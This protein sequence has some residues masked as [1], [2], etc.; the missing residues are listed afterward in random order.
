MKISVAGA[1]LNQ[2]P[3]D[4][5]NNKQNIIY[6]IEYAR[7]NGAK[8]LC[9]PELC[10][11]GYG[12]EDLFLADWVYETAL[13]KLLEI[14]EYCYDITVAVGLPIKFDDKN[15]NCACLIHNTKILGFYAK[16]FLANDGIHYETRWFTPWKWLSVYN[17]KITDEITVPIGDC[18]FNVDGVRIGFEICEE[19]WRKEERPGY[20][21]KER[22]VDIIL[23]PSASHFAFGKTHVRLNELV[24]KGSKEFECVYV[25]SNLLGNEA[26]RAIYDGEILIAQNGKLISRNKLLSFQNFNVQIAEVDLKNP[27]TS[28]S[29]NQPAPFESKEEEFPAALS[30]SLYDYMRKS[31]SNGF[32]LSLSGGADSTTC[33]IMVSEMVRRGTSELGVEYFLTKG[34]IKSDKKTANEVVTQLLT[35]VYQSTKN[36]SENTFQSA[37]ELAIQINANFCNWEVDDIVQS[38]STKAEKVLGRELNWEKDDIAMQNIQARSRSPIIWMMAN[39]KN[40]LLITTSNRSEGDVGYTTMDGDTSGSISPIAGVDKQYIKSWLV[41]AEKNLAYS[42]LKYVNNLEPSAELKPLK[43]SQKDEDDLMPYSIMLEIESQ[44]IKE[45]K[46]PKQV[47]HGLLNKKLCSDQLLKSYIIKFFKLWSR[48][49][50]K[51]ERLAP[52]FHLDEMNVDPRTWCR[53][54]ILNGGFEEELVQ[55]GKIN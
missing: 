28:K 26:G 34:N 15:Y 51:R 47:Y 45:R 10:I 32:V 50:W 23:N 6:A 35:C 1:C 17:F 49:Q 33:A 14:K 21:H 25:F 40:A 11:T 7:M 43:F 30:L 46:S 38:Y 54:P 48:N 53:F 27:K 20:R 55:L 3:I 42:S 52:S 41:W 19:S 13:K 16:Q 29:F 44:A 31:R 2:T 5:E 8:I 24:L 22:G 4:W 37:K 18:I 12:C 9:L 39:L 36:S